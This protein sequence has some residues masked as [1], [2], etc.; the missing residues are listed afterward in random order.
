[1][2]VQHPASGN[3]SRS[4]QRPQTFEGQGLRNDSRVGPIVN[5]GRR[6][7]VQQTPGRLSQRQFT[8]SHGNRIY[9]N[10]LELRRGTRVTASWE[11]RYFPHGYAH[12][13]YYRS[14]F[15]AGDAF[16]SPF[17]FFFGVCD[18]FIAASCCN[19]YPP[20]VMYIDV[21]LYNGSTCIGYSPDPT[22]NWLDSPDLNLEEPGL[23]SAL[24]ELSETFQ[25]GNVDALASLISPNV[26]IAVYLQGKYKY[27]LAANNYVDLT[28]DAIQNTHMD[29]F[30]LTDLRE[31]SPNV[32]CAA[33]KQVY[34]DRNGGTRS[35][36]VS[37]VLQD[38]GGQWTLT[39]VGTA[40]DRIQALH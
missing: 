33:G 4:G 2:G 6:L 38:Y 18:P 23:S 37:F 12:F 9:D 27:S 17:G 19:Y 36:Y 5:G 29:S 1:M 24:D 21:P 7:G 32:F 20:S 16:I 22:G 35:V 34:T 30:D 31:R 26:S 13:P 3:I 28:R 25:G 40:P 11:R 39:Q 15:I 10:G 14:S 8:Q